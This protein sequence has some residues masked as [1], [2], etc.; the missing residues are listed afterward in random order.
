MAA[1]LRARWGYVVHE[2]RDATAVLAK[3]TRS[4]RASLTCSSPDLHL[5]HSDGLQEVARLREALHD[6]ELPALLVTRRHGHRHL[7]AGRCGGRPCHAQSTLAPSASSLELV[8][9][10]IR[11]PSRLAR[12]PPEQRPAHPLSEWVVGIPPE[13]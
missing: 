9:T 7:A 13:T 1:L 3:I 4:I 12:P 8:K 6:P 2:G 10:Y 5:G 11:P